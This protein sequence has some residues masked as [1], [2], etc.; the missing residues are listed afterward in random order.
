MH[1]K[2]PWHDP[3]KGVPPQAETL[4]IE[5]S[6]DKFTADMKKLFQSEKGKPTSS[7]PGPVASS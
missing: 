1:M 4:A 6:F 3:V 2:K 7:S 5:G